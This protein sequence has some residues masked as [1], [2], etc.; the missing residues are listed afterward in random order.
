MDRG[1]EGR[2]TQAVEV[3]DLYQFDLRDKEPERDIYNLEPDRALHKKRERA[4]PVTLVWVPYRGVRLPYRYFALTGTLFALAD[5]MQELRDSC[6]LKQGQGCVLYDI[7]HALRVTDGITMQVS[8]FVR[9][10]AKDARIIVGPQLR[11]AFIDR[12]LE[13]LT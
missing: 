8:M 3:Q 7:W 9:A 12:V 2:V 11:E 1:E 10:Y 5:R 6:P 13:L 4:L